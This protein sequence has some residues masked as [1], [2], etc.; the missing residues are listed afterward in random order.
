MDNHLNILNMEDN[1]NILKM[2]DD[3]NF[4]LNWYLK[5]LKVKK[6]VVAPLRVTLY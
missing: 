3:L 6:M 2:K 4:F 5:Q 1:L